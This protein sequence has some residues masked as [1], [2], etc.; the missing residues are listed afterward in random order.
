[1]VLLSLD[2]P[3]LCSAS[4]SRSLALHA[5]CCTSLLS[6]RSGV[7]VTK[8]GVLTAVSYDAQT[9]GAAQTRL[10]PSERLTPQTVAEAR[11]PEPCE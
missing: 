9:I 11:S 3:H 8:R 10:G 1:M 7:L 4:R 2:E 5:T 6:L